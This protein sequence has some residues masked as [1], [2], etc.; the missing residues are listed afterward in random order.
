VSVYVDS[1]IRWPTTIRCFKAGSC[2]LEADTEEEL[3]AFA[4]RLGLRRSWFQLHALAPHYDLTPGRRDRAVELGAIE[5]TGR[6]RVLARW[7]KRGRALT[8]EHAEERLH[9][10]RRIGV[11]TPERLRVVVH[12]G[13]ELDAEIS[14]DSGLKIWPKAYATEI[15]VNVG[16]FSPLLRVE[17]DR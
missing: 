4:A 7:V 8:L 16:F 6:E 13:V 3:H 15:A 9:T 5:M 14:V 17:S 2:H 11:T 10:L 1:L 12:E